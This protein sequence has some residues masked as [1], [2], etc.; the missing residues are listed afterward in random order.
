MLKDIQ[1]TV[2][3]IKK[4]KPA[5]VPEIPKKLPF[6]AG[7][8]KCSHTGYRGRVVILEMITLDYE[9]RDMILKEESSSSILLA[10][11]RKGL[12]SMRE[13]GVLKVLQ[14]LTTLEEV[15]RVTTIS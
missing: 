12:I 10:A 9:I 2:E 15:F 8:E 7:C 6:A 4:I 14:G 13:D 5:L 1:T 11:R 3:G